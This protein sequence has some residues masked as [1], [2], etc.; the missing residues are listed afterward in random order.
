MS[1]G[2][3]CECLRFEDPGTRLIPE[4]HRVELAGGAGSP[5]STG[6]VTQQKQGAQHMEQR[7][8]N[9]KMLIEEQEDVVARLSEML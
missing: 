2:L 8:A 7:L 1:A 9:A 4:I 5:N 3:G 6:A